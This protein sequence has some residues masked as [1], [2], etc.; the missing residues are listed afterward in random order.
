MKYRVLMT[1]EC[2]RSC[3]GCCNKDWDLSALPVLTVEH[4]TRP[5]VSE[6][7]LTGGEPFLVPGQTRQLLTHAA[8]CQIPKRIVYTTWPGFEEYDRAIAYGATGFTI[9]L[10]TKQD[11]INLERLLFFPLLRQHTLHRMISVRINVFRNIELSRDIK[12]SLPKDGMWEIREGMRWKK[13]CP[14]PE[15]EVFLRYA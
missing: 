10:H 11:A 8:H 3:K 12:E 2:H 6:I 13:N 1:P 9:T 15:D 7:L 14:L 5:G 4:L